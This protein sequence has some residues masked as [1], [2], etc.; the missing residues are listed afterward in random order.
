MSR[1]ITTLILVVTSLAFLIFGGIYVKNSGY[2]EDY[3]EA[4]YLT[5]EEEAER[6]VY[7][8]LS[9]R[10]Q[11]VYTALYRGICEKKKEI[12]LPF[13]IDGEMYSK[14]YCILEKQEGELF[15]IDS[16][17]YTALEIKTATIMFREDSPESVTEKE[18][19][20]VMTVNKI[21]S[22]LP[23]GGGDFE[24]AL[25]IHD[26]IVSNCRYVHENETGYAST[27]YG[28]LVEKVANC[29][30]YA[31]AFACLAREAGLNVILVTGTTDSGENHA[32]NQ[33]KIGGSWYNLDTTWDDLDSSADKRHTYFLCNDA[34]F[35]KTHFAD[36]V[37]GGVYPC[38][39]S[40]ENY[41]VKMDFLV[42]NM[43][44]ADRILRREVA[45]GA[46]IAEL[47]FLD[48]SVYAEFL[49]EYLEKE[50]IFDIVLEYSSPIL[51][52]SITIDVKENEK[53]NSL[54]IYLK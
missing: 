43:D 38:E 52:G 6:P 4:E 26:Y 49:D 35:S 53:E 1:K 24:K 3:P 22:A 37:A 12:A 33:V 21:M 51:G 40:D 48:A 54:A 41:F 20:L 25:Y 5:D 39:H 36:K 16:S 23:T 14:L 2:F 27:V 45:L 44:D 15:Y 50:R 29:E 42:R 31:K 13:E 46:E 28:C 8:R 32:W 7:S 18:N 9:P 19:E 11:A 34:D 30:G 17:Y 47:K 10:E